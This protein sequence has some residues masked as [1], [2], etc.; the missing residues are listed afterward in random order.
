MNNAPVALVAGGSRGLGWLI[1]RELL[2]RGHT[3]AVCARD[4][5]VLAESTSRLATERHGPGTVRG[6][7]CDLTDPTQVTDL[8]RRVREEL[9][10]VEV[11]V[12][13][14]GVI[15]VGPEAATTEADFRASVDTMLWAPIRLAREVLPEMR[16]RGHGRI[17]TITSIGGVVPA[18]HLLPYTTAKFGAVGFSEG[19]AV[20]LSGTGVTST[21]VVPWLM[22]T[23]SHENAW[24][25]GDQAREYA[26][27]GPSA[28]L[29]LLAMNAERAARRIVDGV[30]RGR[31]MVVLTPMAKVAMRVH[32]LAPA[33]TVR[34][35]GLAAR[36]LPSAPDSATHP[37]ARGHEAARRLGSRTV[38]ALTAF[39]SRGARRYQQRSAQRTG[40]DR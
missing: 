15:Q 14:A 32:G 39:G 3:V 19:L 5:A 27:F 1:A 10:P 38:G 35:L 26:W 7:P 23:G 20:E 9:G 29:P 2:Q 4:A 16:A 33:T 18:P 21:T 22:R 6:Y 34:A 30:L 28:S 13:V 25:V 11:L 40:G 31:P 36:L 37:A 17:G 8:V 24:F 12:T